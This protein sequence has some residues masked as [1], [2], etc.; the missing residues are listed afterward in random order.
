[1]IL[2]LKNKQ[3]A[4]TQ[5][6]V[7]HIFYGKYNVIRAVIAIV[8]ILSYLKRKCHFNMNIYMNAFALTKRQK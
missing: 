7:G 3:I 6:N 4:V 8:T 1:M 5:Q 2:V